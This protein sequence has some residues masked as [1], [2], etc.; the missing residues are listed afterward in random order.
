MRTAYGTASEYRLIRGLVLQDC[1]QK[2]QITRNLCVLLSAAAGNAVQ[3]HGLL[4][5]GD[6]FEPVALA[7]RLR[8]TAADRKRICRPDDPAARIA[9]VHHDPIAAADL[10]RRAD[11]RISVGARRELLVFYVGIRLQQPVIKCFGMRRQL[12]KQRMVA[13]QIQTGRNLMEKMQLQILILHALLGG[14]HACGHDGHAAV[15]IGTAMLLREL[16]GQLHGTV[17]LIFQP[18]EEGV[19]GAS[20]VVAAGHLDGADYAL[21]AH[22]FPAGKAAGLVDIGV[23]KENG[24]GGLATSKLDVTFRGRSAHA[25][26]APQE[27]RNALLAAATAV[28][29]LHAIPRFGSTPTQLNVGTLHAG[30]GR[31]VI[32][33]TAKL[34][35]EVRGQTTEAN[36]Y[37]LRRAQQIVKSAA[38]M[39]DCTVETQAMG[40]AAAL[41]CDWT[42][43]E[44]VERVCKETLGLRVMRVGSLGGGSE[45]FSCMAQRVQQQSGQAAYVG[46]L[47]ACPAA[48]HNDHFD[49]DEQALANGAAM[50]TAVTASL[51]A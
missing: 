43:S 47:C 19:R 13:A 23:L 35:L 15:G 46:L 24:Q 27:G 20:S 30:T 29:N 36:E 6:A 18:A 51:L 8:Q 49:F 32:C 44:R 39:Q 37:M 10:I 50:F 26:I 22:V 38:E 21:A 28:L 1:L 2:L 14:R 11:G 3:A 45:D 48:N 25:G 34:E 7:D 41:T 4:R 16:R 5:D 12:L 31:N 33:E 17:R 42:L 9:L 40:H